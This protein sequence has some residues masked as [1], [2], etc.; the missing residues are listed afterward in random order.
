MA[1]ALTDRIAE[2]AEDGSL[3]GPM[4]VRLNKMTSVFD[5]PGV[6]SVLEEARN[7]TL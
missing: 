2:L 5:L 4:L 3:R 6:V 7:V 1:K